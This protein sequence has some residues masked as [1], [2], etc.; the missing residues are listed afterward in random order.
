MCRTIYTSA[1]YLAAVYMVV[2]T[3]WVPVSTCQAADPTTAPAA[4]QAESDALTAKTLAEYI[5]IIKSDKDPAVVLRAFTKACA[6]NRMNP[7]LNSAYM[8]RMLLLGRPRAA[9]MSARIL[10][11]QDSDAGLAWAMIGYMMGRSNKYLDALTA[12]ARA[13][14]FNS[15]DV[16]ILNNAG[17][18]AAWF[19][20]APA[21][22]RL[23]DREKRI[24]DK[25]KNKFQ[26]SQ[27]YKDAYARINS[28]YVAYKNQRAAL[29]AKLTAAQAKYDKTRTEELTMRANIKRINSQIIQLNKKLE[30]LEKD[31]R[32]NR[33]R[34]NITDELGRRVYNQRTILAENTRIQKEIDAAG[35]KKD[36]LRKEGAPLVP[37]IRVATALGIKLRKDIGTYSKTLKGVKPSILRELRWDPPSVDG[38]FTAET[39]NLPRKIKPTT[40]QPGNTV[41][42]SSSETAA[43][44]KLKLAKLYAS[45]KKFKR[46]REIILEIVA[47]HPKTKAAA[48]AKELL[49]SMS[50][51]STAP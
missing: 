11:A 10:S 16:S 9:Y 31:L 29:D 22:P 37:K 6:L 17:Q 39:T 23:G 19:D 5:Q 21:P 4:P 47:K 27:A 18:L 40:T 26:A 35:E 51:E 34:L 41:M 33:S 32:Q 24:M 44:R 2:L 50:P 42:G 49:K 12:T 45:N 3:A 1:V 25:L 8:R 20:N 14:E 15:D 36:A 28:I 13:L 43:A 48:Q 46:A 7:E 30:D 38:V